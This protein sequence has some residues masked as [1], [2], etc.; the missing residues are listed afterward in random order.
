MLRMKTLL[1]ASAGAVLVLGGSAAAAPLLPATVVGTTADQRPV[2]LYA[3]DAVVAS[4]IPVDLSPDT[5]VRTMRVVVPVAAGDVLDV[6]AEGRVTNDLAYNVGI[7]SRLQWYDV[8]DGIAWPHAWPWTTIGTP[9]GDNVDPQRHHMP[10]TLTR[11]YTVPADWPA[12]HRMVINLMVD[13]H[14]TAW[15]SGNTIT[16][17]AYGALIVRKWATA[18]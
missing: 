5:P 7:G 8:D 17:D 9:T 13:A 12:G 16:V 18:Q 14:S 10:L 3:D 2:A 4:T 11:A 1:A 15:R 6:T